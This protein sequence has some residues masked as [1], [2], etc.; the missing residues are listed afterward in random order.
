MSDH[1][2]YSDSILDLTLTSPALRFG[3]EELAKW[4]F[5]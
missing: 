2:P 5:Y 1:G 3:A 4:V